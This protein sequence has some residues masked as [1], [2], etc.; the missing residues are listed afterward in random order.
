MSGLAEQRLIIH[1]LER[2]TA[3]KRDRLIEAIRTI[4]P[5][6]ET[7]M[8]AAGTV[9]IAA[10]LAPGMGAVVGLISGNKGPGERRRRLLEVIHEVPQ[11]VRSIRRLR[12]Q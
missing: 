7:A 1:G 8:V 4:D 9:L 2:A 11:L 5:P 6:A 3:I 10:D 12:L